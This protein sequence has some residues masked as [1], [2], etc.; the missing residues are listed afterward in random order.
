[1]H[2]STILFISLKTTAQK[3]PKPILFRQILIYT[4]VKMRNFLAYL[5]LDLYSVLLK[6]ILFHLCAK[7]IPFFWLCSRFGLQLFFKTCRHFFVRVKALSMTLIFVCVYNCRIS[8]IG[9]SKSK[10]FC[11]SLSLFFVTV[12][13]FVFSKYF[14]LITFQV[15]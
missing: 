2:S 10:S 15:L 14:I 4:F 12:A 11:V 3:L 1:M 8:Y 13:L 6:K 7:K 5:V 9:I